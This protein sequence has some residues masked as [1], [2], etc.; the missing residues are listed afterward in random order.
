MSASPL[1]ADV[2]L[3]RVNV[4][5]GPIADIASRVRSPRLHK[6]TRAYSG[7]PAFRRPSMYSF[8]FDD[9]PRA[10][11]ADIVKAGST[12]SERTAAARA[13]ASHARWAKADARQR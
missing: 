9:Q 5:F 3:Y 11:D 1:E 10:M 7:N 12:S 13:S 2:P 6:Q 4:G 8:M